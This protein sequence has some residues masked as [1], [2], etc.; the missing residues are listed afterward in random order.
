MK[1]ALL[2]VCSTLLLFTSCRQSSRSADSTNSKALA[3]NSAAALNAQDYSKAQELAA[4]ATRLDPEFAEAWVGYGMASVKLGQTDLARKAYERALSLHEVRLQQNPS[5]ANQ[6][7]QQIFLLELLGRSDQAT[8]LLKRAQADHPNDQ[9]ISSLAKDFAA[10][11]KS[12]D[13]WRVKAK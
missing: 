7:F 3:A 9:Q 12:W 1:T 11:K 13:V 6:V 2:I 10:T 4:Q 5:D 8:A